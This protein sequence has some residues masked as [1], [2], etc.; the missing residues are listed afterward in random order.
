MLHTR[1]VLVFVLSFY[2]NAVAHTSD[3]LRIRNDVNINVMAHSVSQMRARNDNKEKKQKK[4]YSFNPV[5]SYSDV[6][7]KQYLL[8]GIITKKKFS[9]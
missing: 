3:F 8:N 5:V 9:T 1:K 4:G 6:S 2:R 7:C